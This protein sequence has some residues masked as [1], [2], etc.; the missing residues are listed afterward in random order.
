MQYNYVSPPSTWERDEPKSL[1]IESRRCRTP[2]S[3]PN[4][5]PPSTTRSSSSRPTSRRSLSQHPN[6][7]G[8]MNANYQMTLSIFT[9]RDGKLLVLKH[10]MSPLFSVRRRNFVSVR[11]FIVSDVDPQYRVSNFYNFFEVATFGL[12]L[13]IK[14]HKKDSI[15]VGHPYF[16]L[17]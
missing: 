17:E 8:Q 9:H 10:E 12:N 13:L 3:A 14:A 4:S 1:Q 5:R 16:F 2:K 11:V 15:L 7:K 6:R